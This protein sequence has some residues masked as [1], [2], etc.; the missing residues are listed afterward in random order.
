[1]SFGRLEKMSAALLQC[2][3]QMRKREV[4]IADKLVDRDD[5]RPDLDDNWF[6]EADAFVGPNLVRRGRPK[7]DNP[8]QP[9]TI[10]LDRDLVDWFKR[11]G[12]GWQTRINS[13]LRRVAGI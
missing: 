9:V 4:D 11:T 6:E 1:M 5:V 3:K 7:S 12:D 2:G 10:R 13:E 8:K